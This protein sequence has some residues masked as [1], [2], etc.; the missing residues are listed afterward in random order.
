MA[1]MSEAEHGC[2]GGITGRYWG[3]GSGRLGK[4]VVRGDETPMLQKE[5]FSIRASPK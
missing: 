5:G 3:M 2:D 4:M 1:D